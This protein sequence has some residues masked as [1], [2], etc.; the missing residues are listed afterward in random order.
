MH[1]G[2]PGLVPE[3]ET[4]LANR[5]FVSLAPHLEETFVGISKSMIQ[6]EHVREVG[7]IGQDRLV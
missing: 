2:M 6:V 5:F 4:G 3:L 1:R 7:G